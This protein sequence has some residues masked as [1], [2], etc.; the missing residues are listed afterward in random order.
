MFQL[1]QL[2]GRLGPDG[3]QKSELAMFQL[4]QSFGHLVPGGLKK[5]EMG[6][7]LPIPWSVVE[8]SATKS[9]I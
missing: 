2:F 6:P 3:S 4:I 9:D 8:F 1:I 7:H 5:S